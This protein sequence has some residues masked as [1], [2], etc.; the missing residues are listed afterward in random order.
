MNATVLFIYVLAYGFLCF[1]LG[2]WVVTQG[3]GK[4]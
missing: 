3:R 1:A 2:V 4:K